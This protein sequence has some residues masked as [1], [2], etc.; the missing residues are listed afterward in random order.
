MQI[1]AA[2]GSVFGAIQQ[3][4]I[5]E[6]QPNVGFGEKQTSAQNS[7]GFLLIEFRTIL[8]RTDSTR[9]NTPPTSSVYVL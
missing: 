3:A 4:D 2:F 8:M 6:E 9:R 5:H 1:S 7:F